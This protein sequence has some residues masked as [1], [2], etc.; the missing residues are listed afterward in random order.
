MLNC[1][2]DVSLISICIFS[3]SF[4]ELFTLSSRI[5]TMSYQ[6]LFNEYVRPKIC[7]QSKLKENIAEKNLRIMNEEAF[8]N[9]KNK[10]TEYNIRRY[11]IANR[12]LQTMLDKRLSSLAKIHGVQCGEIEQAQKQIY[13]DQKK[14]NLF[15]GK[16]DLKWPA[17]LKLGE[18]NNLFR[19][20][21]KQ[22][23]GSPS[24]QR[25]SLFISSSERDNLPFTDIRNYAVYRHPVDP[26]KISNLKEGFGKI[27]IVVMRKEGEKTMRKELVLRSEYKHMNAGK[28]SKKN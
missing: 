26:S 23:Y 16:T 15:Q 3:I 21:L 27:D 18:P 7:I 13:M 25:F 17:E 11:H 10:C 9:S 14:Q 1:Y 20:Y 5:T 24:Q 6:K 2:P 12:N 19:N 4:L 22:R 28:K 8:G